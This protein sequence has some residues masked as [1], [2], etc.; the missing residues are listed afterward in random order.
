MN[1]RDAIKQVAMASTALLLWP[2]CNTVEVP[3]YAKIPLD[4]K[5]WKHL[6]QFAEA[7]LPVNHEL[8]PTL[9]PRAIYVLNIINDCTPQKEVESFNTGLQKFEIFLDENY[10]KS[11]DGFSEAELDQ[12]F[13]DLEHAAT[14]DND[15]AHFIVTTRN[16]AKQ[17]FTTSEKHL[18]EQLEF[19]FIPGTY[20]GCVTI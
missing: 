16:L 17:H 7:I 5:K 15:L 20:L 6:Q 18:T 12:L 3:K 1:R 8:Y 11:L 13:T 4:R 19:Q 9:E 10:R 14:E 2:G